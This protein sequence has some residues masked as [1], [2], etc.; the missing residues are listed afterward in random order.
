MWFS[1]PE[2]LAKLAAAVSQGKTPAEAVQYALE[3]CRESAETMERLAREQ[4]G[5]PGSGANLFSWGRTTEIVERLENWQKNVPKPKKLPATLDEFFRRIVRAK[6]PDREKR[7]RDFLRQVFF[8]NGPN[9]EQQAA[10]RTH[11]IKEA[12]RQGGYFTEAK[13]LEI[14]G[15]YLDWW[16]RQKSSQA[17]SAAKKRRKKQSPA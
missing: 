1:H 10:K 13:W 5:V 7:F 6:T 12:D 4:G 9:S 3:L 8:E 17:R 16:K 2:E 11:E 15:T 14:G